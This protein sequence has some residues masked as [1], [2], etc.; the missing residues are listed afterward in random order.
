MDSN[1]FVERSEC[2]ACQSGNI[3]EIFACG[4]TESPIKDYLEWFYPRQG[5][6]E[7]QYLQNASYLLGECV[8]CGTIFQKYIPDEF[9]S[10]KLY[11]EWI[12]P[13]E[14]YQ[15]HLEQDDLGRFGEY[16]QEIVQLIAYFNVPAHQ[17]HFL[18]F[19]MGW[20]KWVN[21]AQAFGCNCE[22]LEVS[23]TRIEHAKSQGLEVIGPEDIP[24]GKYDFIN[25]EQVFEHI[26]E[27]LGTLQRLRR[28]LKPG[29]LLKINVP[30]G[31]AVKKE[32]SPDAW[33]VPRKASKCLNAVSPL[34]HI[35][36]YNRSSLLRM[37]ELADLAQVEIPVSVQWNYNVNVKGFKGM[38]KGLLR[39]IYRRY[40][41]KGNNIYFKSARPDIAKKSSGDE[42][43]SEFKEV[44]SG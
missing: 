4:F 21:M 19:G 1:H 5:K 44:I 36:C 17:L 16:A 31:S 39:P 2:P 12:D 23:P 3:G 32:L 9:L 27:P 34:E 22:G 43:A 33:A 10:Q 40:V 15:R 20:G 26:P 7:Y 28:A 6:I 42:K 35:N 11:E 24:H 41:V 29:G 37:A 25:C 14:A 30:D 18:D 13:A 38:V 8:D